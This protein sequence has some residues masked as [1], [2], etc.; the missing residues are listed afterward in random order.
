MLYKKGTFSFPF[1]KLKNKDERK[2]VLKLCKQFPVLFAQPS[3]ELFLGVEI[4][5]FLRNIKMYL[6]DNKIMMMK[7]EFM[8]FRAPL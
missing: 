1:A 3:L 4:S 6:V 7:N 2:N 5:F 8:L